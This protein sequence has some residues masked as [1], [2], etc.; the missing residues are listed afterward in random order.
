MSNASALLRSLIVYGLCL[1]LAVTLGY[2]LANPLDLTTVAVVG[3]LIFILMIPVFLRWH[4]A[5]LIASW[6][7]SAVLFFLP[8]R[9]SV[10]LGMVAISFS[11]AVLQYTINRNMK[12]L[13]VP[14]VTRPLL[15]L[16]AVVLITM[17][18]T[19]GIG[20]KAFGSSSYG[21]KNYI[22]ILGAILGYFAL[23]SRQIP[24]K[25][26]ALYVSLFFLGGATLGFGD[27]PVFLPT[28]FSFL[29][30]VFPLLGSGA[31]ALQGA[32]MVGPSRI[33]GLAFLSQAIFAVMLARYGI[34]GIFLEPAKPWR[35]FLFIACCFG[36]LMGG[37]R[38]I[39]IIFT[40]TFAVLFYL[41]RLHHTRMLPAM[42]IIGLLGGTLVITFADRM[43]FAV[44]RSLAILP[45]NIDPAARLSASV[46]SEWRLQMWREVVPQVPQYLILG[47]GYSFSGRELAMIQD[48]PRG[49]S[50]LE[51][52][53]LAGDYHNGPLSVIMPFGIF[54]AIG[55]LWF[56]WAGLR[57]TYQNY[58]FGDPAYHCA[59]AYLFAFFLVKIIFFFTVFGALP[60]DLMMFAGLTGLSISLNGGVA[61]PAVVPQPKAVFNRFKLHPSARRPVSV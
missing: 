23:T 8:G 2:L 52:V 31:M 49:G 42:V 10:W 9:P 18:L 51:S 50:G 57:V 26:A 44:Q 33:T 16:A 5:W 11:I 56:M 32:S 28:G 34:R 6:N 38:S 24:P 21:G 27:L 29:H 13:H 45:V 36:G 48:T 4:H 59:N 15:F 43:P 14:S 54:G 35:A 7:M 58:Q 47:K 55:F 22:L 20:L 37:F 53:E 3:I 39:L 1:P 30:L 12:F 40:M 19:G 46:S 25:R 61:K 60:V 17:R 41:E